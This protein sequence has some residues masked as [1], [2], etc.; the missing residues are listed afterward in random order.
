[1]NLKNFPGSTVPATF[2]TLFHLG[3]AA[4][5]LLYVLFWLKLDLF[6]TL[7]TLGLLGV[8]T[9]FFGHRILSYLALT[10]SKLKSA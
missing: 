9:M 8:F 6:T 1:V 7:K 10:S 4:V 3:L 5:L 2:A